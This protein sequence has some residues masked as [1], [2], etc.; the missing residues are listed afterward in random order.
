MGAEVDNESNRFN[1]EFNVSLKFALHLHEISVKATEARIE[2]DIS[3]YLSLLHSMYL[4]IKPKMLGNEIKETDNAMNDAFN[5]YKE[6]LEEDKNRPKYQ[7][8]GLTSETYT[9]AIKFEEKVREVID[10]LDLFMQ[11]KR[12]LVDSAV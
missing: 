10:R 6:E 4:C 3:L 12:G 5:T 9:K 11:E 7:R 2:G 8:K 1:P